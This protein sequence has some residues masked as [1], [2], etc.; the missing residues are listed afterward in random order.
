M[1]PCTQT[2]AGPLDTVL[3]T[4]AH[5]SKLGSTKQKILSVLLLYSLEPSA[6]CC[7]LHWLSLG[8]SNLV[9]LE[10]SRRYAEFR[11]GK[12]P[13]KSQQTFEQDMYQLHFYN[14]WSKQT[15]FIL[16]HSDVGGE[17]GHSSWPCFIKYHEQ[18]EWKTSI[19][20]YHPLTAKTNCLIHPTLFG[21]AIWIFTCPNSETN[22]ALYKTLGGQEREPQSQ[23]F[24]V[25][26]PALT[27]TKTQKQNPLQP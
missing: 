20:S 18:Y 21:H 8:L 16:K 25:E 9:K 12:A 17:Y 22:N 4:S 15:F 23:W 14:L 2:R 5:F 27:E 13:P 26:E 6:P 11:G 1:I 10:S 19:G 7:S 3:S 24:M